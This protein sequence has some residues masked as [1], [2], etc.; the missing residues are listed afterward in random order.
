MTRRF[1]SSFTH[2]QF[3]TF[4]SFFFFV[5]FVRLQLNENKITLLLLL[6]GLCF[7]FADD[8]RSDHHYRSRL[9]GTTVYGRVTADGATPVAVAFQRT[10]RVRFSRRR[11]QLDRGRWSVGHRR[12]QSSD[13]RKRHRPCMFPGPV[14][15][16]AGVLAQRISW[17]EIIVRPVVERTRR[18]IQTR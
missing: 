12:G 17:T 14:R 5:S 8:L 4:Y 9:P 13:R 16:A 18:H 2:V 6:L 11:L 7:V 1:E 3:P 15:H 10:G